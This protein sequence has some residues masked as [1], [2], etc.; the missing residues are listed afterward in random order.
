MSFRS[1]SSFRSVTFI[2]WLDHIYMSFQDKQL[3]SGSTK[4]IEAEILANH[5]KKEREA[6]KQG[7]RPFY[8]KKCNS[9]LPSMPLS[10]LLPY[11]QSSYLNSLFT[12]CSTLVVLVKIRPIMLMLVIC[13]YMVHETALLTSNYFL[14]GLCF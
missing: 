2:S 14:M 12:Y 9:F 10:L 3:R 4:N 5:K 8:L 6:T 1:L 13:K 11:A 7:K